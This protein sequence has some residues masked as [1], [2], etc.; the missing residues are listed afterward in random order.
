VS[1]LGGFKNSTSKTILDLLEACL[2]ENKVG[3]SIVSYSSQ[4]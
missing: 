2:T 1:E 4:V 3:W